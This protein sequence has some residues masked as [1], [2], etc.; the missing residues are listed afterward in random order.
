MSIVAPDAAGEFERAAGVVI[1]GLSKLPCANIAD[2]MDRLGV[3]E[4]IHAMWSGAKL[5]GP[6]YTIWT[7][8][9]DNR[10][11][12]QAIDAAQPGDVLVVNGGGDTTR[13]LIGELMATRAVKRR[14]GGFVIDGA[15]RDRELIGELG[16]PVF[17]RGA[18]PA[19]PYKN[20]PGRL[21][22]PV[23][24][25]GVCVLPG[26]I[27]LGDGDGVVVVP[28][29]MGATVLEAAREIEKTEFAKRASY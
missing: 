16:L 7:R 28:R 1:E 11:V 3:A 2:A 25:G 10:A 26:D 8:S 9:G 4:G 14:L 6:A 19:G 15:V 29:A 13:A 18:T 21:L 22:C 20:G 5:A 12:H 23:A 24:I 27:V 17:A